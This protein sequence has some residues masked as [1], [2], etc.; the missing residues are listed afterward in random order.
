M[1]GEVI[2]C[3]DMV[4]LFMVTILMKVLIHGGG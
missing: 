1:K 2:L 4:I 3:T